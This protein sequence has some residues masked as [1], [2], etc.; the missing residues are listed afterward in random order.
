M[1]PGAS[2]EKALAKALKKLSMPSVQAGFEQTGNPAHG[3]YATNIAMRL[4][5]QLKRAPIIIAQEI[6]KT[7]QEDSQFRSV[8]D[9]VEIAPPGFI[10]VFFSP[11]WLQSQISTILS[12]G[13]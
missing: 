3:D 13:S 9:K 1:G 4:A 10:N 7:V 2:W 5:G 11:T 12:V 8:V 6:A